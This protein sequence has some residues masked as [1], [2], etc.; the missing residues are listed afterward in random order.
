MI[1]TCIKIFEAFEV[2]NMKFS[3]QSLQKFIII[4]EFPKKIANIL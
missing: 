3:Y 2:I 1:N 4:L